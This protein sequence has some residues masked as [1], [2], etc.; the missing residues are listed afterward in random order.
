MITLRDHLAQV[1]ARKAQ[2]GIVE[3]TA[4]TDAMRNKGGQRTLAKRELLRR[5]DERA[6]AAGRS[7]IVAYY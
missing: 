3:T 6:Q 7:P 4:D 2:L 1:A 5:V